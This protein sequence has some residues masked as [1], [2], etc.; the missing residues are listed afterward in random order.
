[1][2]RMR[3]RLVLDGAMVEGLR[4]KGAGGDKSDAQVV[5]EAAGKGESVCPSKAVVRG[6]RLTTWNRRTNERN[7]VWSWCANTV[8]TLSPC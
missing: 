6:D 4:M 7:G 1:M 2:G 8:H 5:S 3:R